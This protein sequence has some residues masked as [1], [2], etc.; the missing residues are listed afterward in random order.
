MKLSWTAD[1]AGTYTTGATGIVVTV[2]L[3]AP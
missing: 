1:P 3:T 2:S